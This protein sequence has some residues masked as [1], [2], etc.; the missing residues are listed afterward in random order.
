MRAI[1]GDLSYGREWL[2]KTWWPEAVQ[3]VT[4]TLFRDWLKT[5]PDTANRHIAGF[6]AEP[7][8]DGHPAEL[9]A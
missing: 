6:D 2:H 9:R 7:M 4:A 5:T 8:A 3:A 1:A